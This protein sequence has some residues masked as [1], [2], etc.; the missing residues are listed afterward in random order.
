M[1]PQQARPTGTLRGVKEGSTSKAPSISG[2]GSEAGYLYGN[3][4]QRVVGSGLKP[5]L[6]RTATGFVY[7]ALSPMRY[8][9]LKLAWF[10]QHSGE[11]PTPG[12]MENLAYASFLTQ[13]SETP[14]WKE[15]THWR[16]V[17]GPH[18]WYVVPRIQLEN[19]PGNEAQLGLS[20]KVKIQG[21][22]GV[23]YPENKGAITDVKLLQ[24][25]PEQHVITEYNLPVEGLATGDSLLKE[26]KPIALMPILKSRP[27]RFLN[28]LMVDV[29]L[30]QEGKPVDAHSIRLKLY[31]DVFALP[32]YL[33]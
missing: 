2:M 25:R 31:P 17:G 6:G 8:E 28:Q 26:L 11:T 32:I 22:F 7:D 4:S 20:L 12:D 14:L 16:M 23:W 19:P 18:P 27:D 10:N 29:T 30:M 15:I 21:V 9:Q 5:S 33:Y 13:H 1:A 3:A 24:H